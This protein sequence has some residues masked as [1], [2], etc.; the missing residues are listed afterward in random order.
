MTLLTV[1]YDASVLYPA[2]LR[3]LL[4]RLALTNI[5]RAHWTADIHEEWMRNVLQSRRDLAR[6]QLERTRALIDAN[7][8]DCLVKG[9]QS[10]IPRLQLPDPNDR[11]SLDGYFLGQNR[12]WLHGE[13]KTPPFSHEARIEAGFLLRQLQ[14]GVLLALP[15]SRPMPEIGNHWHELRVEDEPQTWR[16]IYRIDPDVIILTEVFKKKT[17]K[18]PPEVITMSQEA[19]GSKR[20]MI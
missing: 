3:D 11:H 1:L 2:P 18:T 20:M 16:I 17:K 19:S 6:E 14:Q 10:L 4:M 13:I 15:H 9:Y 5:F 8:R 7:V 12:T